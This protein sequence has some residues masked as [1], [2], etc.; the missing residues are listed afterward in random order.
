MRDGFR[1]AVAVLVS[2][3][4]WLLPVSSPAQALPAALPSTIT[5]SSKAA[6]ARS[7]SQ[8]HVLGRSVEDRVIEYRQFGEGDRQVLLV[9]PFEGDETAALELIE[10]LAEHLERFPRRATGVRVTLVR[11]P[12]PD[13][14]LRRTAANARGV[15]LDRNF[16]TRGW[17]KVPS[18]V[19][20]LSGR[21][22]ESEPETRV[23]VDLV[24]DVRPDR[25]IVLGATRRNGE[26]T[27]V[28]PAEELARDFA[29][30]SG[31]R[32]VAANTT[33]EQGS[34]AVYTGADRNL[35]TLVVRVPAG[36]RRDVLWTTYKRALLAAI[37]GDDSDS[38]VAQGLSPAPQ[39]LAVLA[40][41]KRPPSESATSKSAGKKPAN[42]P[43]VLAAEELEFGGELVPVAPV[44]REFGPAMAQQHVP[45]PPVKP[46]APYPAASVRAKVN[47]GFPPATLVRP[48]ANAVNPLPTTTPPKAPTSS[49]TKGVER[50]PAVE[51][52]Q[53]VP[54]RSMPQPIP[55][56]PET[57]Y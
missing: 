8:W 48:S 52:T 39:P 6:Q 1:L 22:P 44:R 16:P 12:N 7:P 18:G 53:P 45:P 11:D 3:G 34:L 17:R 20:W 43:R 38:E 29:K 57:G 4:Y 41:A 49:G 9:G 30:S 13:G 26:L 19:T 14:R 25:V 28:G 31:L 50:L 2:A 23:L 36:T 47:G 24:D 55:L 46:S 21:E 27:Y 40:T 5:F 56:Y 33:A 32:P 54:P 42:P 10:Q 37:G 51:T 15:R 35:P